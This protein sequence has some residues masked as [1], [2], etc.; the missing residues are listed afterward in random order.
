MITQFKI[1]SM[2]PFFFF[3]VN[4]FFYSLTWI[5]LITFTALLKPSKI[6]IFFINKLYGKKANTCTLN[7]FPGSIMG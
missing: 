1:R 7:K 5:I 3:N 4:F 6:N 2:F